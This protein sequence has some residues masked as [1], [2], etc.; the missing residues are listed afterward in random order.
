MTHS[1]RIL[2]ALIVFGFITSLV[3]SEEE[4]QMS[5]SISR[6]VLHD[7]IRGG[8]TGQILANL[9]GLKHEFRYIDEPGVVEHY[10]PNLKDGAR[11]DDDTDIEW[12]YAIAMQEQGLFVPHD[13]FSGLWQSKINRAI[14]C[15]HQ[16]V[17]HLFDLGI[18]AELT[19]FP[20][21]NPWGEF[22]I[23]G[24]FASE[25]FGLISPG[26]PQT[27]SKLG[28]HYL[29]V[30]VDAE[31]L[32]TTQL[33]DTMIATAFFTDNIDEILDAGIA[34][35]DPK[36]DIH[37]VVTQVRT[38]CRENPDDWKKTRQLIRDKY[39]RHNGAMRD[40]N[41]YEL[42]TAATIAAFLYGQG[43]YAYTAWY[44]FSFGWDADNT[45]A[46][47]GTIIGVM[48][49]EKW[50]QNQ[51]WEIVDVFKNTTRDNMPDD[52]TITSYGDRL[53]ELAEKNI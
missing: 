7:K 23:A 32:Q 21:I 5:R 17:R 43:D 3:H 46:T 18:P 27:A 11:T 48:R 12:V 36:S 16:Y 28:T 13:Q 26:M 10:V 39:T 19:G 33:Y 42:N 49:G 53:I 45:A 14:W 22:N 41:G 47:A 35:V 25:M 1:I 24:Q 30:A 50:F 52:E 9:N 15:S 20:E 31:P 29:R 44:A 6:D 4:S 38:W 37:E 34:A 51:G 2:C 40:R 8:L